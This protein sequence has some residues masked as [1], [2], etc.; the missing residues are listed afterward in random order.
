MVT[1][2]Q[3]KKVLAVV[4]TAAGIAAVG[5]QVWRA[6]PSPG[7]GGPAVAGRSRRP[8]TGAR[9]AGPETVPIIDLGRLQHEAAGL[10]AGERDVFAFGGSGPSA[11]PLAGAPSVPVPAPAPPPAMVAPPASGAA[12]VGPGT[13]GF[14]PLPF[15]FIGRITASSGVMVAALLTDSKEVV[16]GREGDMVA[17]RYRVAHIGEE[18]VDI[19]D[20][21]SGREQRIRLG[22]K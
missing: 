6:G 22:G 13:G 1:T 8:A 21:I 7:G 11:G 14:A 17:L 10:E 15:K 19:V 12:G 3:N 18:S 16:T 9:K 5:V 20:V 4:L 2:P